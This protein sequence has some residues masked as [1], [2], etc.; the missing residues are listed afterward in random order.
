MTTSID[1]GSPDT[2]PATRSHERESLLRGAEA[3]RD[4]ILRNATRAESDRTLPPESLH[5]L[6]DQ[7]FF[8]MAAPREVGGLAVDPITEAEVIEAIAV[9]DASAAWTVMIGASA[10]S[11]LGYAVPE[12]GAAEIF[13]GEWPSVASNA[14]PTTQTAQRAE[15]GYVFNGK[16]AFASGIRHATWVI[17]GARHGDGAVIGV[18]PRSAVTL[19]DD[20]HV[21]GLSGTGSC[22]FTVD[23]LF[24]PDHLTSALPPVSRR[25]GP[26]HSLIEFQFT[27]SIGFLS[28]VARRSLTEIREQAVAKWRPYQTGTVA[29]RPYFQHVLGELDVKLSAARGHAYQTLSEY[30]TAVAGGT[31]PSAGD[32]SKLMAVITY[33]SDVAAEVTATAMRFGGAGAAYLTNPLQRNAR[34]IAMAV[35]NAILSE[36]NFEAYGRDLIGLDAAA[37]ASV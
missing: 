19:I 32:R 26:R 27:P 17:F 7:G 3:V 12:Q 21:A 35:Q 10:V 6:R 23:G 14:T 22:S 36:R 33:L 24:V 5:A 18:A 34:D 25:G 2:E 31:A 11:S 20:W 29:E 8:R 13:G 4:V 9:H 1:A 15:G 28:G 16:W 30:W 37:A